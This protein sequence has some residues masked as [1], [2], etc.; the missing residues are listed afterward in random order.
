MF[1]NKCGS[2]IE[3]GSMFCA[4]CGAPVTSEA[5]PQDVVEQ[6]TP[7]E[8]IAEQTVPQQN[9][10]QASEEQIS[11]EEITQEQAPK[12]SFCINCGA[13]LEEGSAFCIK[14]GS[15][16]DSQDAEPDRKSFF[17]KLNKKIII[18]V[19]VAVLAVVVVVGIVTTP[20]VSNQF[21]KLILPSDAY[22]QYVV[23]NNV[24]DSADK[25]TAVLNEYRELQENGFSQNGELEIEVGKGLNALV[26]KVSGENLPSEVNWVKEASLDY[27][28]ASKDGKTSLEMEVALNDEDIAKAKLVADANGDSVYLSLPEMN[29][30]PIRFDLGD[31]ASGADTSQ[32][33]A[34]MNELLEVIPSEKAINKLVVKYVKCIVKQ[35]DQV[36]E[37]SE[38]VTVDGVTQK[39]T[40]STVRID[41]RLLKNAAI[42]ALEEARD[43]KE[44]KEIITD[45]QN[46]PTLN[47]PDDL[48]NDYLSAVNEGLSAL[49]SDDASFMGDEY[50]DLSLYIDGSGEIVGARVYLENDITEIEGRYIQVQKGNKYAE[51]LNVSQKTSS[52]GDM[53]VEVCFKGNGK[54]SMGKKTGEYKLTAMGFEIG[55]ITVEKLDTEKLEEGVVNG[56]IILKPGKSI[57]SMLSMSTGDSSLK[58]ISD[59]ELVIDSDSKSIKNE[60]AK[61]ALYYKGDMCLAVHSD[62]KI[63]GAK[64]VKLPNSFANGSDGELAQNWAKSNDYNKFF[65]NLSDAGMPANILSELKDILY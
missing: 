15:G 64:N 30:Q 53:D 55:A 25:I 29:S 23:K 21:M 44:I 37:K 61:I 13:E 18:R 39:L 12:Q 22:F 20:W 16:T 31:I 63:G 4:D 17:K 7:Q 58:F 24:V 56:K 46:A 33:N 47:A 54:I 35:V 49:R 45:L 32:A 50:I 43:D 48:Y 34:V 1:C 19:V 5:Q 10:E 26:S 9:E 14:C 42:A 36:N 11:E 41:D 59:I 52:S 6:E 62:Y 8:E 57:G 51:E 28:S 65:D 38:A 2:K 60:D 40:V 3:E 27:E